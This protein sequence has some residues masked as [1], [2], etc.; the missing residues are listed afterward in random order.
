MSLNTGAS[1][2]YSTELSQTSETFGAIDLR[3]RAGSERG[4]AF[5]L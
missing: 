3:S 2:Q 1:I 5:D 4:H